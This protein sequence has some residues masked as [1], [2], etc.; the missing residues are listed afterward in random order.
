MT[1]ST[2]ELTWDKPLSDGGSEISSYAVELSENDLPQYHKVGSTMATKFTITSLV[3]GKMYNIRI[4]AVNTIGE[5]EP[6]FLSEPVVPKDIFG[7]KSLTKS[8]IQVSST[9]IR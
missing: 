8:E 7:K 3:E 1:N 2:V 6:V 5:S 4:K 9:S